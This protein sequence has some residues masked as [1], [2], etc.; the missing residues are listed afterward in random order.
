MAPFS[1]HLINRQVSRICDS[2]T[3]SYGV[4]FLEDDIEYLEKQLERNRIL[5]EL[6]PNGKDI[7]DMDGERIKTRVKIP[8]GGGLSFPLYQ[9]KPLIAYRLKQLQK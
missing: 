1:G 2:T 7:F 6:L 8:I 9:W 3:T 4:D 5:H